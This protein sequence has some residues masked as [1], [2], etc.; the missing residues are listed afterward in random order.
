MSVETLEQKI[1]KQEERLRQLKAQKQAI[2][3]REKK[4]VSDQQRKD[5]T[6]R[7]ILLGAWALNKLKNDESFK[8]QLADFEQFLNTEN[9]T[10]EN[11]QKDKDL[12]NGFIW[13]KT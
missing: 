9:K 7:K 6:R 4:K 5:D 8:Q 10:E 11:K 1:A 3:A 2:A 12:F 13:D